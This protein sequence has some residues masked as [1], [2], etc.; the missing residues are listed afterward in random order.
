MDFAISLG[1]II[2]PKKQLEKMF[3]EFK[4]IFER[5]EL[6]FKFME[7]LVKDFE[8]FVTFVVS[9]LSISTQTLWNSNEKLILELYVQGNNIIQREFENLLYGRI[10]QRHHRSNLDTAD[11]EHSKVSERWLTTSIDN[12]LQQKLNKKQ[13]HETE[14]IELA[15]PTYGNQLEELFLLKLYDLQKLLTKQYNFQFITEHLNEQKN[16]FIKEMSIGDN[17]EIVFKT[18]SNNL[19]PSDYLKLIKSYILPP[20]DEFKAKRRRIV[21]EEDDDGIINRDKSAQ[22]K[23]SISGNIFITCNDHLFNIICFFKLVKT[24]VVFIAMLEKTR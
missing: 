21:I 10:F 14:I 6:K 17:N 3:A 24:I 2:E 18:P 13:K 5:F 15:L 22:E 23:D 8:D 4:K 16:A 7:E 20:R 11:S 9:K 1:Y 19:H 12:I